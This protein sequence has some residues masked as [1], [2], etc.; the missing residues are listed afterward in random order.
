[1][2]LLR[3]DEATIL[4]RVNGERE[5]CVLLDDNDDQ[6][7]RLADTLTGWL[8]GKRSCLARYFYLATKYIWQRNII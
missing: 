8:V 5:I 2:K 6:T 3:Y 1:M 7:T 4:T